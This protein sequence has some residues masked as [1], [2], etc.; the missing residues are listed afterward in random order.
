MNDVPPSLY[1]A[2]PIMPGFA[3]VVLVIAL[4]LLFYILMV[5]ISNMV[6]P[7][8]DQEGEQNVPSAF[9]EC[10]DC[11]HV[12]DYMLDAGV[13]FADRGATWQGRWESIEGNAYW[14]LTAYSRPSNKYPDNDSIWYQCGRRRESTRVNS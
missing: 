1:E 13:S 14:H 11:V 2:L 4:G 6:P 8:E 10:K 5:P 3:F 7:Y 12:I 9:P